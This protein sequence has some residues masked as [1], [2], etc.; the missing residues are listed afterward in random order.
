MS[1]GYPIERGLRRCIASASCAAVRRD[2]SCAEP[3]VFEALVVDVRW[4]IGARMRRMCARDGFH[5]SFESREAAAA[6]LGRTE[7]A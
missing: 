3:I 4:V 2:G 1:S 5:R 6:K 7:R